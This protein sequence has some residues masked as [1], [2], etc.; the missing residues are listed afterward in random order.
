MFVQ[1]STQILLLYFL[2]Y[3]VM[4]QNFLFL[5]SSEKLFDLSLGVG[6]H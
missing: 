3:L 1:F 6:F 4:I 5:V 2:L